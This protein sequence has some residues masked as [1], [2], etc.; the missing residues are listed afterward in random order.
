[1]RVVFDTNT[2]VSAL[3]FRDGQLHWLRSRWR[4]GGVVALASSATVG[5]LIRVLAYPKFRLASDDIHALLSDYL[6]FTEVVSVAARRSAPQC[7]DPADQI[8]VDLAL[9]GG[10]DVLVSG[11]RALLAMR[12]ALLVETPAEYRRRVV[13]PSS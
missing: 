10:A 9:Q 13:E 12:P 7:R 1:M 2:V 5:E 4:G 3:L 6:P 11:D 8:F